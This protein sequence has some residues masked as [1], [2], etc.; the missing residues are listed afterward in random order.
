VK[1]HPADDGLHRIKLLVL[2]AMHSPNSKVAYDHALSDFLS[3]Y[4][5]NAPGEAFSKGLVQRW[6]ASLQSSGLS[7]STINLRL[8]AVKKLASEAQDNGLL[9]PTLAHGIG[10]VKGIKRAGVRVGNW[11]TKAQAEALLNSPD[12]TTLKGNRDRALLAVLIGCGLRRTELSNM[13]FDHIQQR[14][15]RWVLIDL[16]GK[17]GRIRSVP[18]PGFAKAAIDSWTAAAGIR[19]GLVFRS[20]NNK[21]QLTGNGLLAQNI[22]DAVIKYGAEIGSERLAPHDLRR[23]FAK[24]AHGGHSPLEQIQLSLGHASIQTTERYL[25]VSQDLTDAPCD[26]LGIRL[27][28]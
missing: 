20:M 9:D 18:M 15:G 16:I 28:V 22:M 14:D 27:K 26:H 10:R 4:R 23:T 11:L 12:I 21:G 8:S 2:D 5:V 3:W 17:G 24:L 6:M 25:G 1:A 7:A 19:D 13:T